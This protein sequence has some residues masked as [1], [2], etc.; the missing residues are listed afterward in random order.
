MFSIFESCNCYC[1]WN[2]AILECFDVIH[3]EIMQIG[4][5]RHLKI[6]KD[7]ENKKSEDS[8]GLRR[9]YKWRNSIPMSQDILHRNKHPKRRKNRHFSTKLRTHT[10]RAWPCKLFYLYSPKTNYNVSHG[11]CNLSLVLEIVNW[12]PTYFVALKKESG[13]S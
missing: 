8:R 13:L 5:A 6:C 2:I 9:H 12:I 7:F 1:S 10:P 4:K 11:H 3:K